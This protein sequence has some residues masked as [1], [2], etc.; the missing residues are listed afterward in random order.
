MNTVV[1]SMTTTT[2]R[3]GKDWNDIGMVDVPDPESQAK[4]S[5]W[6]DLID[7]VLKEHA[8]CAHYMSFSSEIL[9]CT[10]HAGYVPPSDADRSLVPLLDLNSIMDEIKER[11]V[12]LW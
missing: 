11:A 1:C 8:R 4:Q 2:I 3:G 10:A 6:L 9:C 5:A 7:E 12:R